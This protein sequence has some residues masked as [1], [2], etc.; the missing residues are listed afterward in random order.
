MNRNPLGQSSTR[1]GNPPY[2]GN[3]PPPSIKAAQAEM[4]ALGK[5]IEGMQIQLN[6]RGPAFF[7]TKIEYDDWKSRTNYAMS[8]RR[9]ELGFLERW[10]VGQTSPSARSFNSSASTMPEIARQIRDRAVRLAGEIESRVGGGYTN[11][12]PPLDLDEAG[13]RLSQLQTAILE[14]QAA[15][16]EVTAEWTAHPLRRDGMS[17]AKAPLQ[18]VL[19]N[20]QIEMRLIKDY[21]RS[22][23][24]GEVSHNW[25]G[26]L[27]GAIDRAVG[28]GLI[29][30]EVEKSVWLEV[31]QALLE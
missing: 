18:A 12:R 8:R 3:N 13:S 19:T 28:E 24:R 9:G 22:V 30:T 15:F 25:Q 20:V 10:L 4:E 16:T 26:V 11:E 7:A 6:T 27:V 31:K 17:G 1:S 14:L 21:V 23:K 5:K 29:L 2:N